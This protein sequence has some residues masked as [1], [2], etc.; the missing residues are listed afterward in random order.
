MNTLLPIVLLIVSNSFMTCAWYLHLREMGGKPLWIA[1]LFSW[2][3]A[4][5]EYLFLVPSTRLGLQGGAFSLQQFRIVQEIVSL[6]VF[7]PFAILYMRQP[8]TLNFL[9]AA[10]CLAGA[11]YFIF[12]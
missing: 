3:I 10:I 12:R 1:I 6:S 9:W 11:V 5:F 7:V 8:M 2:G 4:F